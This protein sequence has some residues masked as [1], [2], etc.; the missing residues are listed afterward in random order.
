PYLGRLEVRCTDFR[1]EERSTVGGLAVFTLAFIEAGGTAQGLFR[2]DVAPVAAAS[3]AAETLRTVAVDSWQERIAAAGPPGRSALAIAGRVRALADYVRALPYTGP[4]AEVASLLRDGRAL[5]DAAI[6]LVA[7]PSDLAGSVRE[8]V[9]GIASAFE[10]RRARVAVLL[11]LL[12]QSPTRS[13]APVSGL[14]AS[15]AA[16]EDATDDLIRALAAAQVVDD[17]GEADWEFLGQATAALE[18]L[19]AGVDEL[20]DR[21]DAATY[22]ALTGLV[23]AAP[24]VMPTEPASLPELERVEL[25][26]SAPALVVAYERYGDASRDGELAARNPRAVRHPGRLPA[27]ETLE[28]LSS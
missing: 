23:A 4:A 9:V 10:S 16:S 19:Q 2:A 6:D 22:G 20:A 12:E 21:A 18:R 13:A 17:A 1:V 5:A 15:R 28:V 11:D 25:G 3:E 7:V 14:F 26:R 24:D 27:A 8:I